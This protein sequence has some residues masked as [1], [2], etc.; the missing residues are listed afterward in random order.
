LNG[1]LLSDF[2]LSALVAFH[3]RR[4][5]KATIGLKE[6]QDTTGFGLVDLEDDGTISGFREKAG[7]SDGGPGLVNS[8]V[9]VLEREVIEAVAPGREVSIEREVFPR[10]TGPGLAGLVL[11]GYWMDIGT[12]D[13][14]LQATWDIVEGRME[15]SSDLAG[16]GP[17]IAPTASVAP[18]A[19]VGPRAV[20]SADCVVEGGAEVSGSVMLEGSRVGTNARVIDSILASGA[21]VDADESVSEAVIGQ[22]EEQD[23]RRRS[24]DT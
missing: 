5:A 22:N 18:G 12:P 8:G 21:V 24:G 23:D 20:V 1:D 4:E 14:Y 16:S 17:V 15:G 7:T 9:Y 6:V 13:R 2:D 3:Q 10:L 11:D 19:K